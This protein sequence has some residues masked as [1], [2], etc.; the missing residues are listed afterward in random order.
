MSKFIL[1]ILPPVLFSA[2][3]LSGCISGPKIDDQIANQHYSQDIAHSQK[4]TLRYVRRFLY[5]KSIRRMAIAE[6]LDQEVEKAQK[7]G[8]AFYHGDVALIGDAISGG[9]GSTLGFGMG[10]G[11]AIAD[12]FLTDDGSHTFVSGAYLPEVYNGVKLDTADTARTVLLDETLTKLQLIADTYGLTLTCEF[13]CDD[14][15]QNQVW[16]MEGVGKPEMGQYIYRPTPILVR[17]KV[18]EFVEPTEADKVI[19]SEFIGAEVK[20]VSQ[21]IHGYAVEF[22]SDHSYSNTKG[23]YNSPFDILIKYHIY[24]DMARLIYNTNNLFHGRARNTWH[25]MYIGGNYYRSASEKPLEYTTEIPLLPVNPV[26][27]PSREKVI[28]GLLSNTGEQKMGG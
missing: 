14:K 16:R 19:M 5:D 20:W 22:Y 6:A 11:L 23:I 27:V 15:I 9:L 17:V 26:P 8:G 12:A 1:N 7:S 3:A 18:K 4:V 28:E 24:R 21:Y 2:I 10:V 25:E 13:D